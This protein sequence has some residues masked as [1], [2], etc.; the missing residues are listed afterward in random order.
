MEVLKSIVNWELWQKVQKPRKIQT[1]INL[2]PKINLEEFFLT[3]DKLPIKGRDVI[4]FDI[5]GN[6]YNCYLA[7]CPEDTNCVI[8]L[9][10]RK[11]KNLNIDVLVWKYDENFLWI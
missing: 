2:N 4:A 11:N 6:V 5:E 9:D 8:W 7:N 10:S 3:K 1:E